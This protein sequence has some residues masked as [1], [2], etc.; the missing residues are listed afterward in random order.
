VHIVQFDRDQKIR[1]IRQYWDQGS[2]LKQIEVIGSR[3]RNW[4]IRDGKDQARLIANSATAEQQNGTSS[5]RST[6]SGQSDVVQSRGRS[7]ASS[8]T[9]ATGDPHA[10]LSL[11]QPRS[12]NEENERLGGPSVAPRSSA[13]PPSRDLTNILSGEET[14]PLTPRGISPRKNNNGGAP[15][16]GAG[17]HYHPIRLFE[18][19]EGPADIRSPEKKTNPKKYKHF[20]FGDGEEA[21]QLKAAVN[22]K[23]QSQWHFEDFVTPDKP[24]MKIRTHEKRT[25]ESLGEDEVS[26]ESSPSPSRAH[27]DKNDSQ[28]EKSPVFRPVVHHARPDAEQHFAFEDDG[29]PSGDKVRPPRKHKNGLSLYDD[30]VGYQSDEDT[31]KQPLSQITNVNQKDRHKTFDPAFEFNDQSPSV[32]RSTN[33]ENGKPKVGDNT[34]KVLKGMNANWQAYDESP[35]VS[36]RKEN[37]PKS[38]GIKLGGD[39]MGGNKG[40]S[41]SWGFGDE[42]DTESSSKPRTK[43]TTHKPDENK[44]FWDF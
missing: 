26:T 22:V 31:A 7:H 32:S 35:D 43:G 4:P 10:T 1:Q 19:G 30:N 12:V 37:M 13:K 17:A 14:E 29:T 24:K 44:S 21:A 27:I 40:A 16:T 33:N 25:M 2:L 3:A 20:D 39:G 38:R 36:A 5:R 34:A 42:S 23:H 28:A 8:T 6:A 9:S 18:E 41:R 11:F 15:K